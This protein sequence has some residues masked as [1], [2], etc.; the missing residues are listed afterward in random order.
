MTKYYLIF[1]GLALELLA[2]LWLI[3][4][5]SSNSDAML[6][7]MLH[8]IAAMSFALGTYPRLNRFKADS[9]RLALFSLSFFLP[10]VGPLLF[11]VLTID[12]GRNLQ[13]SGSNWQ[14]IEPLKANSRTF[15][16]KH[17][18]ATTLKALV[19]HSRNPETRLEALNKTSKLGPHAARPILQAALKDP[20]ELVRKTAFELLEGRNTNE[21]IEIGSLLEIMD[22]NPASLTDTNIQAEAAAQLWE[23]AYQ[24]FADAEAV[25]GFLQRANAHL[26]RAMSGDEV[27]PE[28][29]FQR[30]R[31]RLKLNDPNAARQDF[32]TALHLGQSPDEILPYLAECAFVE[33]RYDLVKAKLRELTPIRQ[34]SGR[35]NKV[36]SIWMAAT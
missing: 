18:S 13:N 29:Y 34:N 12:T 9:G 28:L 4:N 10:L 6:A 19:V 14:V 5:P 22:K 36:I 33:E 16:S 20:S 31:I 24:G 15:K 2:A 21:H 27:A 26:H 25:E 3:G 30:G 7:L 1:F 17:A 32:E 35:F 23:L 8:L 11:T